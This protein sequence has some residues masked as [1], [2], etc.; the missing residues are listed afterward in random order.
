MEIKSSLLHK[1]CAFF[2]IKRCKT[3]SHFVTMFATWYFISHRAVSNTGATVINKFLLSYT[4][5]LYWNKALWLYTTSHMTI[6]TNKNALFQHI[7]AKTGGGSMLT[8]SA[9]AKYVISSKGVCMV[10]LNKCTIFGQH[11]VV[12]S[13]HSGDMQFGEQKFQINLDPS[14]FV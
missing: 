9:L 5:V 1:I 14:K 10:V 7:Y 12:W 13:I 3:R 4:V 8:K 11:K 6:L 2:A